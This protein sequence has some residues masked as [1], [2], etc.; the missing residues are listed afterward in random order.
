MRRGRWDNWVTLAAGL[1]LALSWVWHSMLGLSGG[2][3]LALGL[4]V[5]MASVISIPRPGALSG[6]A[7][8]AGLGVL[9][10]LLPWI[11]GFTYA[12]VAA[13]SAW[14]LGAAIT[15]LGVFGFMQ[16]R[17][18]RQRDPELAWGTYNQGAQV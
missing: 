11:M 13:W 3:L 12:P 18:T 1:A 7:A 14:I 15:A 8:I 10:F 17:S 9:A 16:A 5:I 6:V 2:M 4:A